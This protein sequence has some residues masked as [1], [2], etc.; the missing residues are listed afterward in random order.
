MP[1]SVQSFWSSV[2]AQQI[3]IVTKAAA[4]PAPTH[5]A[6]VAGV[7]LAAGGAVVAML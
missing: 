4:G 2:G 1:T 3:S 7:I 6:K 5:A